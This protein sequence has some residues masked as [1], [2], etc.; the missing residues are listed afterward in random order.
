MNGWTH[1]SSLRLWFTRKAALSA[2]APSSVI[3][4]LLRLQNDR[5]QKKEGVRESTLC[6]EFSK[7][8]LIW[9]IPS[10]NLRASMINLFPLAIHSY[11][12]TDSMV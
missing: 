5:Q 11:C 8:N 6:L 9:S 3:P 12:A 2:Q 1:F 7:Q 10:R 4:L